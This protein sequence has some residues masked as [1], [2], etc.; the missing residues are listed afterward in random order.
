MLMTLRSLKRLRAWA[1]RRAGTCGS[2]FVGAAVTSIGYEPSRRSWS[3]CN[4]CR[5]LLCA[6]V[7]LTQGEPVP[8]NFPYKWHTQW[9]TLADKFRGWVPLPA[10]PGP[11]CGH[12]R[13]PPCWRDDAPGRS[14]AARYAVLIAAAVSGPGWRCGWR[15]GPSGSATARLPAG[16]GQ[17]QGFNRP[18]TIAP[19]GCCQL[20]A[21]PPCSSAQSSPRTYF[22]S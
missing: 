14:H 9:R 12:T 22:A 3:A 13:R 11:P 15:P 4:C 7:F 2:T 10:G 8:Y 18:A 1:G 17:G 16:P 19:R 21:I 5:K 6:N 20:A